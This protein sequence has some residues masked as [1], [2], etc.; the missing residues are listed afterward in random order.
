MFAGDFQPLNWLFCDGRELSRTSYNDL[1]DVIGTTYG[2]G[3]GV[4]TFNLPDLRG[5]APV[6]YVPGDP[7]YQPGQKGGV[8]TVTLGLNQIPSHSHSLNVQSNFATRNSPKDGV[9]AVPFLTT[10]YCP[11]SA[12]KVDGSTET[13]S[14]VGANQAHSNMQPYVVSF[15]S[16]NWERPAM[17]YFRFFLD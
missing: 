5:R 10:N 12:P 8:E 3:N 2:A 4:S 6:H 16:A 9:L 1:F 11:S 7:N 14:P 15:S 13:L 17:Q